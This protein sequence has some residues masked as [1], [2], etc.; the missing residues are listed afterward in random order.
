MLAQIDTASTRP[1]GPKSARLVSKLGREDDPR[2]ASLIAAHVN[3]IPM[4][5]SPEALAEADK[6]REPGLEG[7]T[8][9][10]ALPL[11]TIDPPDARDHDDAVFAEPDSD[12]KN[13]RR[14]DRVGGDRRRRRLRPP[15]LG[16][17]PRG[18]R[19]GQQRLFPGPGGADAAGGALGRPVLASRGRAA[20]L[21]GRADGVR[22]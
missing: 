2:A 9:L 7:R 17:R 20:G 19:E 21:H 6:A 22:R 18:A 10:R 16:P 4:G 3:G 13:P 5:F 14:L 15:R 11:V 8:D 12:P 1:H